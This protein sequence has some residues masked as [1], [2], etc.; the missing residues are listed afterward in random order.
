MRKI[1]VNPGFA[2]ASLYLGLLIIVVLFLI[3]K[4]KGC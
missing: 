1:T 2:R 3:F 4:A